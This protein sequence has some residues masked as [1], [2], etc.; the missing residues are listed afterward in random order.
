MWEMCVISQIENG[1]FFS[2]VCWSWCLFL[3]NSVFS[4]FMVDLEIGHDGNNFWWCFAIMMFIMMIIKTS[5]SLCTSLLL[6]SNSLGV[7]VW[8]K[9]IWKNFKFWVCFFKLLTRKF[10]SFY[11]LNSK[12]LL[13]IYLVWSKRNIVSVKFYDLAKVSWK[14]Y[15]DS[16]HRTDR[17][18]YFFSNLGT[19]KG[20]LLCIV[21]LQLPFQN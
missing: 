17:F 6:K 21:Y 3:P 16:T 14:F 18:N 7:Q 5:T 19:H 15:V 11:L 9:R 2:V 12:D 1:A 13:W 20:I 4:D 8:E 10:K